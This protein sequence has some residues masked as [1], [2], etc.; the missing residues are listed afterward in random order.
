[1]AALA[2]L[3]CDLESPHIILPI[4]RLVTFVLSQLLEKLPK[5]VRGM[6]MTLLKPVFRQDQPVSKDGQLDAAEQ[7]RRYMLSNLAGFIAV[8]RHREKMKCAFYVYL[9][10]TIIVHGYQS[11]MYMHPLQRDLLAAS[12]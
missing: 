6:G 3:G 9:H 5:T 10:E 4:S 2:C 12:K 7:G 11:I 1:M 8:V